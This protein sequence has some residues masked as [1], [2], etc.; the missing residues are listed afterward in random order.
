VTSGE[1]PEFE[2]LACVD[3]KK[4]WNTHREGRNVANVKLAIAETKR[5][6]QPILTQC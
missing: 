1:S 4:T 2:R 6:V 3:S 5:G